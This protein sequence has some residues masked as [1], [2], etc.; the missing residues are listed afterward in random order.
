MRANHCR[1][2]ELAEVEA[3]ADERAAAHRA[4]A[5]EARLLL[6]EAESGS[7]RGAELQTRERAQAAATTS[8][9]EM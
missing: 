1:Q 9:A 8:G 5:L 6:A 3:A 4:E 2:G 7:S